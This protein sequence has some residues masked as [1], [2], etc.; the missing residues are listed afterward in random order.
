MKKLL[1]VLAL[2]P[3]FAAAHSQSPREIRAFSAEDRVTVAID[4][5]NLN[6]YTQ[7][8]EVI[9]DGSVLG[10][11]TLVP[12][13]EKKIQLNVK[14]DK[15]DAW[16]HKIVSTRSIPGKGQTTRSEI[17]SLISIYGLVIKQGEDK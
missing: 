15:K 11:F 4:V 16:N 10:K 6:S 2:M 5:T 13:E 1:L 17:E 14:V 7:S 8:Y 3:F 12:D 9:V